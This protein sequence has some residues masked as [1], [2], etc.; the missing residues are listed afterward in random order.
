MKPIARTSLIT[1]AALTMLVSGAAISLPTAQADESAAGPSTELLVSLGHEYL[2]QR[3]DAVTVGAAKASMVTNVPVTASMNVELD[4]EYEKL[5]DLAVAYQEADGGY[6]GAEVTVTPTGEVEVN[7]D[8]ATL[9]VEEE[10]KLF[11]VL[12]AKDRAEGTP[13]AEEYVVPHELVFKQAADGA[14]RLADDKADTGALPPSHYA[15]E[16]DLTPLTDESGGDPDGPEGDRGEAA[17]TGGDPATDTKSVQIYAGYN[18][19]A[20]AAYANKHW[21]NYNSD[22][23]KYDNDC[24]NFISQAMRK[25]GWKTTSGSVSSRKDNKKWFYGSWSSSTSYTWAGAENWYWFAQKHSKR[26]HSLKSVWDMGL[27]DVLQADWDRNDNINHTMIVT[28]NTS[29]DRYLTYHTPSTH[30]RSMKKIL[31]KYPKAW[32]YAHRT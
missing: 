16:P 30:N 29:K 18:Y 5:S 7:G 25:G 21:K 14:W 20:M 27:A 8:T 13:E 10:T 4:V 26:T 31:A 28:K 6:S 2:A 22:Y 32:W 11:N 15:A 17:E 9:N 3:A 24:T 23:R 19:P 1:S 12:T